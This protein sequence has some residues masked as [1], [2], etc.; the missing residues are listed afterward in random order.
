MAQVRLEAGAMVGRY[1][2]LQPVAAGGMG[3]VYAA[4]D[5]KLERKVALKLLRPEWHDPGRIDESYGRLQREA[6]ALA[7]VSHPNVVAVHDVGTFDGQIFLAMELVD[8]ATVREWLERGKRS[9][10]EILAVFMQAGNGLAAA[11]AVGITHRDFKPDNVVIGRDGRV[12]VVDFGL[13]RTDVLALAHSAP[14]PSREVDTGATLTQA[15][16]I[17]GTPA[18]MAPEQRLG[19]L[20]DGRTDQFSFCVALYEALYGELPF[21]GQTLSVLATEIAKGRVKDPP[22]GNR[23]PGWLRRALLRGLNATAAERYATMDELLGVLSRDPT[24]AYRRWAAMTLGALVVVGAV[25][26]VERFRERRSMLC[27]GADQKLA[28][29][30][31]PDRKRA[32]EAAFRATGLAYVDA[33]LDTVQRDFDRYGAEWV[34]AHVGACEATRVR[35]EQSEA[36]LV[37]APGG[38]GARGRLRDG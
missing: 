5:P 7:R 2:I 20:V 9:W 15:G 4:Y 17:V 25:F 6:Q 10:R 23:T 19:E 16:A 31:N 11:H 12:R 35:G 27:S 28:G 22:K 33:T 37:A 36:M 29:V 21:R 3:L 26:A 13:A 32:V 38:Q 8:G 18:Y 1:M 30:W 34:A 24:I 14:M